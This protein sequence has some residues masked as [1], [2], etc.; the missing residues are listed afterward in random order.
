MLI[1]NRSR[2]HGL[3]R[4]EVTLQQLE[5]REILGDSSE[6]PL[7]SAAV[8]EPAIEGA[9]PTEAMLAEVALVTELPLSAIAT[10]IPSFVPQ[11]QPTIAPMHL[12]DSPEAPLLPRTS[13]GSL[14]KRSRNST[15]PLLAASLIETLR[16]RVLAWQ[17]E[18]TQLAQQAHALH[19]EGPLLDGWLE[20]YEL[21]G[22]R[23]TEPQLQ[24]DTRPGWQQRYRLRGIDEQGR[25]WCRDCPPDQVPSASLAIARA[26]KLR[27]LLSR[28]H[29]LE[30]R[31]ANLAE[32]LITLLAQTSQ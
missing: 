6:P 4:I 7:R 16:G 3:K 31:L 22:V 21:P 14:A 19:N 26:Q 2:Q 1:R 18:L 25:N 10:A 29:E 23:V 13:L 8:E 17:A 20:S 12:Q 24:S 27:H 5:V 32:E 28:Q 30:D 9:A 15:N 11:S